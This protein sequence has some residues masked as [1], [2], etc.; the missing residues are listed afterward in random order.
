MSLADAWSAFTRLTATQHG[1]AS[2][3]QAREVGLDPKRVAAR[4][5]DHLLVE[6]VPGVLVVPG[7]PSTF[8]QRLAIATFAGHGTVASHRSGVL[9]HELD[10]QPAPVEVSVRRGRYPTI[11][12][13]VVHRA[14]P[15]DGRDVTVVDGIPVTSIARTL[16]DLGAVLRQDEV[17]RCLDAALRRGTSE[18]WIRETLERVHRPGPSGT[19]TLARILADPRRSGGVP[20][21]WFERV[22]RRA[23]D[24]PDL[25]PIVLQHEVRHGGRVIARFDAAFPAWRIAVEA[26]SAEWHDRPGRTWRDMERD[27]QVKALGWSVVYVTWSLARRPAEV[28]DLIRRTHAS[29]A[30][31]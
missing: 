10:P 20:E 25:P 9:L 4:K 11:D 28:L 18:S 26:H 13:V 7:M 29:R 21:S 5:R 31:S 30:A 6:P 22:V 1:V 16:C 8:R 14:T 17:E 24:A 27:N 19:H 23:V 15:F 12:G 2:R 3:R